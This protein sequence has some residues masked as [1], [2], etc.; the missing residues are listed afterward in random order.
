MEPLF[1]QA[2]LDAEEPQ[3]F[4]GHEGYR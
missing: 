2:H 4:T 3:V 1:E